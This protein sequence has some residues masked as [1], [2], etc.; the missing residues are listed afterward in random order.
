[1]S[2]SAYSN[3]LLMTPFGWPLHVQPSHSPNS[4]LNQ[5]MQGAGS[6]MMRLAAIGG[7]EAGIDPSRLRHARAHPAASDSEEF[8]AMMDAIIEGWLE[9]RDLPH[10][11]P[12]VIYT[13]VECGLLDIELRLGRGREVGVRLVPTPLTDT[14][15]VQLAALLRPAAPH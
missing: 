13:F 15:D 14:D 3:G 12:D 8:I 9:H 10:V 1:V 5:P 2:V 11:T 4:V 6:D 7:T